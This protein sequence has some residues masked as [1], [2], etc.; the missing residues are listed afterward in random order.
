[1]AGGERKMLATSRGFFLREYGNFLQSICG[2]HY[3]CSR[4]HSNEIL[5]SI[6]RLPEKFCFIYLFQPLI[7][8]SNN[9][10][11]YKYLVFCV[12]LCYLL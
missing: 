11:K 1:M 2:N 10:Y 12:I 4:R 3:R 5:L 8:S 7:V 9:K 6:W